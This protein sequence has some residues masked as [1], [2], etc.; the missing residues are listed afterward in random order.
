MHSE[1]V[2]FHGD[3]TPAEFKVT[4]FLANGHGYVTE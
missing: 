2:T 4:I 1:C 3:H